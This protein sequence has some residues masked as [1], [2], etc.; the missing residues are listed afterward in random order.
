M[1]KKMISIMFLLFCCS[2]QVYA[3][4]AEI[5]MSGNDNY[6]AVRLTPEIYNN[7]NSNLSDIL[8]LDSN[9][10]AVPYFVYS[11]QQSEYETRETTPMKLINAYTKNDKFYFDYQL[12]QQQQRDTVSTSIECIS[13]NTNFAKEV[14]IYGS[15]DN[16]YWEFIQN[17]KLYAIDD[18]SKSEIIFHH[19]QKYTYYRIE[20]ANNLEKISFDAVNLVYNVK[21]SEKSYFIESLTPHYTIENKD[22]MTYINVEGLKNLRLC[23][24][25]IDTNTMF[26]RT[27]LSSLSAAKEIYS[28]TLRDEAYANTTLPIDGKISYDDIFQITIL[29]N[30]DKPIEILGI[31]VRYY[32]DEIVFK[33]IAD[34]KYM[35]YFD[36]DDTKIAPVYDIERYKEEILK[37]P[38]DIV[39]IG[40]VNYTEEKIVSAKWDFKALFNIV[41]I[42]I[43]ILLGGLILFQLKRK[44]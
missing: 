27:A 12:E 18:K 4:T 31:T 9:G 32:V 13:K 28:I 26:Q 38:I 6:K 20:L 19:R 40:P 43:A 36:A 14:N 39:S 24:I 37:G 1:G 10:Q 11:G 8:I 35:L 21:E 23:D 15:Y 29:N 44:Q 33:P 30:D 5:Q 3:N 16:I 34:E 41:V 42:G 2:T 25:T 22:K 7:A 17:D